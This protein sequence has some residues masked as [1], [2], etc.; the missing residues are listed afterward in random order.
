[1]YSDP[2]RLVVGKS[3]FPRSELEPLIGRSRVWVLVAA[4]SP[5]AGS[6][7]V[8]SFD[9]VGKREIIV[10]TRDDVTAA[11]L[12]DLSRQGNANAELRWAVRA[13]AAQS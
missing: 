10:E 5:E 4:A 2:P 8:S 1:M 9:R 3:D 13:E 6:S 7:L 12:Y 11:Y